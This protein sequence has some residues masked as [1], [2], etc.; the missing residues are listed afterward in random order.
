MAVFFIL[1]EGYCVIIEK[2]IDKKLAN[3]M[4]S[5]LKRCLKGKFGTGSKSTKEGPHPL[6][7]LDRGSISVSGF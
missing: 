5:N 2:H 3:R 6:A 1:I 7:D 4:L